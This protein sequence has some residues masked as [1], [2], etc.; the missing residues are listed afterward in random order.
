M[1]LAVRI[2]LIA[3]LALLIGLIAHEGSSILTPIVRAGWVLLWLVPLHTLP[4]VLDSRGWQA[5]LEERLAPGVLFWIATVRESVNRLLPVAN[6][7]GE[8]V[9]IRLLAA[10]GTDGVV[11]AASVTTETLLS[12]FSQYLFVALGV[13]CL[14][15][16]THTVHSVSEALIGMGASLPMIVLLSVLLR[17]GSV[18][19]RLEK[20][21]VRFLGEETLSFLNGKS[22][23]LDA[24]I[25]A[26]I[27]QPARLL[28]TL[29]WQFAGLLASVLE[30][31]LALRWLGHPVGFGAAIALESLTQVA[32][33]FIFLVPAGLG[34]QE[35]TL[36]GVGHLLGIDGDLAL[37]LSL[38]KRMRE[39]LFGAPVLLSWYWIEGRKELQHV[40]G[41]S[42]P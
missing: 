19:E 11:A 29:G 26:L 39:I 28:G 18:F 30:T 6:I 31:W 3:G 15:R 37:A 12:L 21:A 4:I 24:A 1:R 2:A 5:L 36:V 22:A 34:V 35:A 13:S 14:L 16:V 40:R 33:N 38:A 23:S 8:L 42:R 9:G 10:Q 7:G 20:L 27:A 25:R 41:P 32:R 17:Y